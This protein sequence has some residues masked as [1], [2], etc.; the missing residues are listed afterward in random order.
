V[1][2]HWSYRVLHAACIPYGMEWAHDLRTAAQKPVA[3][4]LKLHTGY[5]HFLGAQVKAFMETHELQHKVHFIASHGH[6]VMHEPASGTTFQLG[7]GAAIAAETGL[8]VISDL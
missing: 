5:G 3:D 2:G 1:R 7:D 6:T 8:P 4:F